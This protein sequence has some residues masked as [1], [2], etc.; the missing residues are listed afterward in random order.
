MAGI[1][2]NGG[3]EGGGVGEEHARGLDE[4]AGG[5]AHAHGCE[6]HGVGAVAATEGDITL[7]RGLVFLF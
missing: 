1:R 5:P 3:L 2:D 7:W 4:I 6:S